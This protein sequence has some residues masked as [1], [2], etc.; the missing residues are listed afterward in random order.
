MKLHNSKLGEKFHFLILHILTKSDEVFS[1]WYR[2]LAR[3]GWSGFEKAL[4]WDPSQM[5]TC[6]PKQI[7]K[8]LLKG[9]V[10]QF[11]RK[12]VIFLL[13]SS[14]YFC[15]FVCQ[16]LNDHFQ[17]YISYSR[18]MCL[19][20]KNVQHILKRCFLIKSEYLLFT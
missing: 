4:T 13:Q 11:C 6:H 3:G 14:K 16:A 12:I 9:G 8:F 7:P 15:F 2:R 19:S 1:F 20:C 10:V 5:I 18:H 17:L